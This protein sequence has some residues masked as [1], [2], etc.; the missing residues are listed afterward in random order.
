MNKRL[1][2]TDRQ[3]YTH[4]NIETDRQRERHTRP[5]TPRL[6]QGKQTD[7]QTDIQTDAGGNKRNTDM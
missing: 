4:I 1:R 3:S 6:T 2:H 5:Q 7:R